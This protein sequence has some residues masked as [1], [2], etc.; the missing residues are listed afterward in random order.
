MKTGKIKH[1]FPGGNTPQGFFSYYDHI[2]PDATRFFIL[3]GGPGTGKSTFMKKI[4]A[5]LINEG[6]DVEYHHC[7]SDNKSLDGVMVPALQVAFVDGTAPHVVDPKNPGVVDEIIYLGDFWCEESMAANKAK[8]IACNAE[9]GKN[10]KRAYRVLKAAKCLYDDWEAANYEAMDF[11]M[12]NKKANEVLGRIF[13]SSNEIG[14][15]K[16]RKLFA[17]A[18]TPEGPIHYLD[19]VVGIMPR[20]FV[21]TGDPGTGKAT[22]LKKVLDTAAA[23]GLDAEAYYCPLDPEKV[24]HIVVPSLGVALTTSVRP[25]C[26]PVDGAELVIDMNDCLNLDIAKR[27]TAIVEYDRENFWTLFDKAI[28]YISQSKKLHD[29]LETYYVPYMNF[30]GIQALW[31]KTRARVKGYAK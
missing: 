6:Y 3:K 2:L 21:I 11:A 8:V 4:G 18:I 16:V 19:S 10:F 27:Y 13:G 1:V 17:S 9:I 15:G 22:L 29:E 30:A 14:A 7:S 25:H 12:A 24:E 26:I 31:E 20:L 28:S 23:K 5:S